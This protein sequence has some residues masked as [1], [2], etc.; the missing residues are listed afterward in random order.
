[1]MA[2]GNNRFELVVEV[3]ANKTNASIKS[4]NAGCRFVEQGAGGGKAARA[5]SARIDGLTVRM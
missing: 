4:V 2:T 5:A 1:M 3:D